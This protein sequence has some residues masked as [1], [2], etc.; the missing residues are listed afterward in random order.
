M[1]DVTSLAYRCTPACDNEQHPG[2]VITCT[3]DK[4]ALLDQSRDIC[5]AGTKAVHAVQLVISRIV[6]SS[7][8]CSISW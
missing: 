3:R 2:N 6:F 8:L 4:I 5:R 1:A 7:I